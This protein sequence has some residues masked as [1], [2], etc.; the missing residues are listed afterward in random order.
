MIKYL[1][2]LWKKFFGKTSKALPENVG[3]VVRHTSTDLPVIILEPKA[4]PLHCSIH[5]R[6]K[7]SCPDCLTAVGVR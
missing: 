7:K 6:F 4:A 1:K 2:K 3:E 5:N